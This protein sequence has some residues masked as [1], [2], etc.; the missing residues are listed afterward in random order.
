MSPARSSLLNA[1]RSPEDMNQAWVE[2]AVGRTYGST[3]LITGVP[4]K[5]TE[6]GCLLYTSPSPRDS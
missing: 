1:L 2:A 6:D 5:Q 3:L 4:T